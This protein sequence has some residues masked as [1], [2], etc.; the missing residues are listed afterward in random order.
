MG[1]QEAAVEFGVLVAG[2]LQL[3]DLVAVEAGQVF[4]QLSGLFEDFRQGAAIGR[5]QMM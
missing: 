5:W 4:A 2:Q 3:D 1:H